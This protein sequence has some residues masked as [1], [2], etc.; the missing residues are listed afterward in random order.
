MVFSQCCFANF[1]FADDNS[2]FEIINRFCPKERTDK[3]NHH[4]D[5]TVMRIVLFIE[6]HL[7][8]LCWQKEVGRRGDAGVGVSDHTYPQLSTGKHT[9][10]V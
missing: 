10:N 2:G 5:M 6:I 4:H 7:L 8:S 9:R 3:D 1:G